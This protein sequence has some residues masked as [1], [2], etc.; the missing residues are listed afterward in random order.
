MP[1][2]CYQCMTCLEGVELVLP[3]KDSNK[4]P[5]CPQCKT[6][7]DRNYGLEACNASTDFTDPI[8]GDRMGVAVSQ[9]AE[10]RRL[11]PSIELTDDGQTVVRSMAHERKTDKALHQQFTDPE[12]VGKKN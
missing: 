6:K 12:F 10:H 4:R 2:Y 5:A 9:V 3:M 8:L 1:T 11:F 7:M